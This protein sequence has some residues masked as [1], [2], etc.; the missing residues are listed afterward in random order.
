MFITHGEEVLKRITPKV[1]TIKNHK[2]N[3]PF[4]SNFHF[5][6]DCPQM[7]TNTLPPPPKKKTKKQWSIFFGG[8]GTFLSIERVLPK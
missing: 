6:N 8:E 7:T 2:R 1:N 5:K 3:R 4:T